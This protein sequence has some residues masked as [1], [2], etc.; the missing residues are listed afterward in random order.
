PD[1]CA[2]ELVR[3]NNL[4]DTGD[5]FGGPELMED[6]KANIRTEKFCEIDTYGLEM[7]A[8]K[9]KGKPLTGILAVIYWAV[10]PVAADSGGAYPEAVV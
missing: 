1:T 4:S 7:F 6:S 10:G 2:V 9:K 5:R 8:R 3:V